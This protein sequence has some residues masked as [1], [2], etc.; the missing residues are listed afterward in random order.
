MGY[1]ATLRRLETRLRKRKAKEAKAK[2]KQ[3]IKNKIESIRKQLSK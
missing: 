3:A 2:A 1:A